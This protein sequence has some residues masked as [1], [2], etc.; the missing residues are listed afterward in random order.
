MSFCILKQAGCRLRPR[1]A[2]GPP[3]SEQ[4][5]PPRAPRPRAQ[6]LKVRLACSSLNVP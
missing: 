3:E 2:W 5:A 4:R 1:Q 6:D